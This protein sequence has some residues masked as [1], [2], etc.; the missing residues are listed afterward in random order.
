MALKGNAGRV[1]SGSHMLS[2]AA[3]P[4]ATMRAAVKGVAIGA[5]RTRNAMAFTELLTVP[6]YNDAWTHDDGVTYSTTGDSLVFLGTATTHKTARTSIATTDTFSQYKTDASGITCKAALGQMFTAL[7]EHGAQPF[8]SADGE[9]FYP[10]FLHSRVMHDVKKALDEDLRYINSGMSLVSGRIPQYNGL[11][12][13]IDDTLISPASGAGGINVY[14]AIAMGQGYLCKAALPYT[15]LPQ[16]A[17]RI[18][19]RM[20][21]SDEM[22]MRIVSGQDTSAYSRNL[23]WAGYFGY[24]IGL[25]KAGIRWEVASSLG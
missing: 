22:E 21:L 16:D 5:A 12:F 14:H 17:Q 15:S 24:G 4:E 10:L 8:I 9:M 13:I 7:S 1:L 20:P 19:D 18:I 23:V 6:A 3:K 2:G 25:P 11:A